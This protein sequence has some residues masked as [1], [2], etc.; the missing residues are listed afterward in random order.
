MILLAQQRPGG[1]QK[2]LHQLGHPPDDPKRTQ[3]RLLPNIR[4]RT[5]HQ[6]LHLAGQIAGHFR[7]RDRTQ[8]AQRQP[9]HKLR[10]TVQ[11]AGNV[12]NRQINIPVAFL[13][14]K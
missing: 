13:L 11:V 1:R 12:E 8:R 10:G 3:R 14:Y 6:P 5:L 9:H 2:D 4:V 7:R